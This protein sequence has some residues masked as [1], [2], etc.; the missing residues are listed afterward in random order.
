MPQS[1]GRIQQLWHYPV[2]SMVGKTTD[3][4][5]ITKAGM[6]GDRGWI[7]RD[8]EN[9]ENTVVRTLPKLLMFAAE[10]VTP[11]SGNSIPDVCI[12]F[13]DGS[14][15]LSSD[16][17][18]NERL[19]AT[20]GKAVSLWPLQPKSNW[21]HYRLRT[22]MGSKE[23][24]R[25][26]ASKDL[27]DFS[28][29]SWK[30]LSELMLFSTPLGHYYDV[31]PLHVLTTAALKKMQQIEPDGDFGP[32][33]FRPNMVIE[34]NDGVVG[35]DDFDWVGG[36][37]FIGSEVVIQVESPTVRCSMPAQPQHDAG[38]DSRVLRAIDRH[39]HRHFGINT[40]VVKAGTIKIGDE[41][42]WQPASHSAFSQRFNAL[43][44]NAK[45]TVSHG[46]LNL[47]DRFLKS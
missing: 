11:V 42:R 46:L 27:P 13:P 2:K 28:S 26:F 17:G 41:V 1:V 24:K 32:H 29:I 21:Q 22:V 47:V 15:A 45:N 3:T 37:L 38:K 39:T 10:Y 12:T 7:V 35:F 23:M 9:N 16:P 30:L 31:Y 43:S 18:I 14:T 20:L 5:I 6:L 19:S 36:K 40:T 33:R 34:S 8:E 25:M 44:G 4:A